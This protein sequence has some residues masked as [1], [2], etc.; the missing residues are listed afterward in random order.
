MAKAIGTT[1]TTGNNPRFYIW[2]VTIATILG[3]VLAGAAAVLFTATDGPEYHVWMIAIA[4][5][6]GLGLAAIGFVAFS[7]D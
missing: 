4:T 2:L 7:G 6:A 1:Q 5:M 3:T